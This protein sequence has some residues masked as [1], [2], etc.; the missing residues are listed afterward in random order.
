MPRAP[1]IDGYRALGLVRN[2]FVAEQTAGVEPAVWLDRAGQ[3]PAPQ[4]IARR[5]VQL[6]GPRGAG[7]TSLLLHWQAQ[8]PGPYHYVEADWRR[9]RFPPLAPLVYWDE[10]DRLAAPVRWLAMRA[11]AARGSTIVAATHIDLAPLAQRHGLTVTTHTFAPIS[12]DELLAWAVRRI[13]H[14]RLPDQP[15]GLTLAP[16]LAAQIVT[17]AGTSW[18]VAADLLHIW[19][20]ERAKAAQTAL[21]FGTDLTAIPD[22]FDLAA[23]L[24]G[25]HVSD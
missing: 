4:P 5:L 22:T 17:H 13:D 25:Y 7:K 1:I 21:E 20:A 18:R 12:T 19:A 10:L 11:A 14:A 23:R 6:L 2:P 3:P 24:R 8:Q 15:L 9:W 16:A